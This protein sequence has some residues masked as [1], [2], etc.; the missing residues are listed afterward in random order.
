MEL[1]RSTG[2]GVL[3]ETVVHHR[4]GERSQVSCGISSFSDSF[5]KS[6]GENES[7][8]SLLSLSGWSV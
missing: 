1:T 4:A 2:G 5:S 6:T 7:Q 3:K 8:L